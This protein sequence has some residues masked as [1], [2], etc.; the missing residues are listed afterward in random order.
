ML[1]K[2]SKSDFG[3]E[4][5]LDITDSTKIKSLENEVNYWKRKYETLVENPTW[6]NDRLNS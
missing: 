2:I 6:N 3:D 1:E 4:G 5:D